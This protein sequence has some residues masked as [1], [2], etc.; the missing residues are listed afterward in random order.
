[1][2]STGSCL[3]FVCNEQ[4]RFKTIAQAVIQAV[5]QA[6]GMFVIRSY[7]ICTMSHRTVH[8]QLFPY[9]PLNLWPSAPCL[10][11]VLVLHTSV[12]SLKRW[13]HPDVCYSPRCTSFPFPCILPLGPHFYSN[14]NVTALS[15]S[16]NTSCCCILFSHWATK[17]GARCTRMG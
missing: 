3:T 8:Q 10:H 1:M 16:Y 13:L 7:C 17:T 14:L 5:S 12:T 2:V 11:H 6:L 15:E 4:L 9:T